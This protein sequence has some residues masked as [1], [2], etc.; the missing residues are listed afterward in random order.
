[1]AASPLQALASIDFLL[2]SELPATGEDL[3]MATPAGQTPEETEQ[4]VNDLFDSLE[5]T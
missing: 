2:V 1:L 3:R 5:L 4:Q